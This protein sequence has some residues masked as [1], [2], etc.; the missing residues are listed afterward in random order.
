M[1]GALVIKG[2][3]GLSVFGGVIRLALY[4]S[5]VRLGACG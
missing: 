1:R 5:N 3:E 4:L 2:S